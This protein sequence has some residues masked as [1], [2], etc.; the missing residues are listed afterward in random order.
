MLDF[1]QVLTMIC[2]ILMVLAEV[3]SVSALGDDTASI[4]AVWSAKVDI[5]HT[6]F[7]VDS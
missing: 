3:V 2:Q 6:V 7:W 4:L 1:F 5:W